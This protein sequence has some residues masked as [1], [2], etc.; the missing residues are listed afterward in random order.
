MWIRD[1]GPGVVELAFRA[2]VMIA[3]GLF[4]VAAI[5]ELLRPYMPLVIVAAVGAGVVAWRRRGTTW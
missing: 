5:A 2:V 1:R 3:I 4:A